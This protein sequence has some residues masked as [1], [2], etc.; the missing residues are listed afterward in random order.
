[1][2]FLHDFIKI[3]SCI[4]NK[5]S[6]IN[7]QIHFYLTGLFKEKQIHRSTRSVFVNT[8]FIIVLKTEQIRNYKF[9]N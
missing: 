8:Y 9:T 6:T 5:K 7:D 1:M 2:D 3:F 4:I